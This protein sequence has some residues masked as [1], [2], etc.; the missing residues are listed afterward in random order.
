MRDW[1]SVLG[2]NTVHEPGKVVSDGTVE[3]Y[4]A[5]DSARY[6]QANRMLYDLRSDVDFAI[7]EHRAGDLTSAELDRLE[8]SIAELGALLRGSGQLVPKGV[9]I[10]VARQFL[11]S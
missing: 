6:H 4:S 5:G 2:I 1:I 3:A 10:R 8:A 7:E 9:P 11:L